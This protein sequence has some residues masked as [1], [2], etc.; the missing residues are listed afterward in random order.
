MRD[1]AHR[2]TWEQQDNL[3]LPHA[4]GL[5]YSEIIFCEIIDIEF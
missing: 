3:Q 1:R 2:D 4:P 5:R